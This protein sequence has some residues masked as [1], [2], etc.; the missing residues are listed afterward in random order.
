LKKKEKTISDFGEFNLIE[1]VKKIFPKINLPDVLLGIGDDTAVIPINEKKAL[2]ITCDIQVEDQHFRLKHISAYQLGRRAIAVNL[3]DIASMGGRPTSALVSLALPP[4]FTLDNYDQ[5]F[6]GIKDE[7]Q[8]YSAF[9]IGG[10]LAQSS[11]QL[12]VDITLMGEISSDEIL[13]RSGAGMDDRIFVTGALGASGAG[14]A[15]L[16]KFG[17]NYPADFSHLVEAHLVPNARVETGQTI[18]HS[19]IATAMID[20]SDGIASDLYH[21]CQSS[22]VGAELFEKKIPLPPK[23]A[24]AAK[25][26]QKSPTQLALYSGEDYE[27]LFTINAKTPDSE[28]E[29]LRKQ[30]PDPTHEI[31][32]IVSKKSGYHLINYQDEHIPIVPRGWD[33]FTR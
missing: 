31:G 16:E 30:I 11:H 28:I 24:E 13:T 14:Y 4:N 33:H 2:L 29:T 21:I 10:N 25:I 27:L 9:V 23:M 22:D 17:N 8:K 19:G 7:L 1:R 18:A 15:I 20:I 12:V 3:S 5:L 32:R 26:C 6:L